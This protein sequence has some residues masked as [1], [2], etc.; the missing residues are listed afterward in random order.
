MAAPVTALHRYDE[1]QMELAPLLPKLEGWMDAYRDKRLKPRDA[2]I[3]LRFMQES[4][5]LF[6]ATTKMLE[7]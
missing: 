1:Q 5:R 4:E 7:A 2:S 3:H 6:K